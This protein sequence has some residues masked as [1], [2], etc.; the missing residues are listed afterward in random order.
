MHS[1]NERR[2]NEW[3]HEIKIARAQ[4]P[5]GPWSSEPDRIEW[6]HKGAPC[7]MVRS[8]TTGAWCGYVG[9]TRD[10][11]YHG[12]PP[13]DLDHLAAHGG[14]NFAS[15]CVGPICHVPEPGESDDVYWIGFDCAHGFDDQPMFHYMERKYGMETPGALRRLYN[16]GMSYRDVAYVKAQVERLAEQLASSQ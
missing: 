9:V 11:P 4:W 10:H 12:K 3:K 16:V 14:V 6:R 8:V 13:E 7:L 1:E 15:P 5:E 2:A